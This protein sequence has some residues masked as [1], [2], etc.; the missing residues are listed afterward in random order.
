MTASAALAGAAENDGSLYRQV[1]R[2]Q[3][4]HLRNMLLLMAPSVMLVALFFVIPV[5]LFMFRSIDN[6][7][8]LAKLPRTTSAMQ[9]WDG[10]D[11][12]S[13][14]VYEAA[15]S[16]LSQMTEAQAA[17]VGR[18]LNYVLPGFRSLVVK[19]VNNLPETMEAGQFQAGMTGIDARWSDPLYMATLRQQSGPLTPFQLLAAVDLRID[20]EGNVV[21][22][23]GEAAVFRGL[24]LRTLGTSLVVTLLC[25]V[26][27]YPIANVM[28]TAKP[29][30][31]RRLMLLVLVPFWTSLLVRTTAWVILLQTEGLVNNSLQWL[32]LINEPLKLIY[33]QTGVYIAMVHVLLPYMILPLYSVMQNV[34]ANHLKAA[35]SLGASPL[36][37]FRSI[38]FPLT[39]PGVAAGCLLVFVSS[40]GF[41]VTP[42]LVGGP[43]D[44]MIGYFIAYFTNA[45][46]NWGLAAALGTYLLLMIALV[47]LVVGKL[48]GFDKLRIR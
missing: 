4:Q 10:K 24:F 36:E 20:Q 38:Y 33:N 9:A 42:A 37:V 46:V 14:A 28:A 26:I 7:D 6:G 5:A 34:Q 43:S 41:Y 31:A 22:V 15:F 12:P 40:V 1:K 45:S 8:M 29:A 30:T 35:A 44:Q 17:A 21:D 47:Y 48:V 25:L 19:T 2:S 18:G 27:G 23:E 3:R 13:E 16:D 39:M 32:G 11:L